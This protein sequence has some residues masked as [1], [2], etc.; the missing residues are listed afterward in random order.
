MSSFSSTSTLNPIIPQPVLI[1]GIALT[2]LQDLALGLVE[3]HEVHMSPLLKLVQVPLDGIPSLSHAS[4][5]P[6]LPDFLHLGTESSCALWKASLKICQLCS[7]PLSLRTNSQGVLLTNSLKSWNF[8]FLKFRPRLPPI[9]TS[10]MSSLA[11]VTIRSS[12]TSPLKE[13]EREKEV[14]IGPEDQYL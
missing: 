12:I 14:V 3:P 5:F 11:L 2:P 9:L 6:S 1:P 8:A 4:F 7:A 13:S 10:L